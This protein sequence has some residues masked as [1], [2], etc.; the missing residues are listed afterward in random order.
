M[1]Y[2]HN[3]FRSIDAST[4]PLGFLRRPSRKTTT[5]PTYHGNSMIRFRLKDT[6]KNSFKTMDISSLLNIDLGN[7]NDSILI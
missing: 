6:T 7:L 4:F 2:L 1:V 3:F 5:I